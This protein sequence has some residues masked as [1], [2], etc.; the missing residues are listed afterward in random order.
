[1]YGW[2]STLLDREELEA[3]GCFFWGR[4]QISGN[5]G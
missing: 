2:L 5:Q 3:D 4:W 1:V